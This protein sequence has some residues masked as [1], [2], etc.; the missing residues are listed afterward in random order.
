MCIYYVILFQYILC[1]LVKCVTAA[2]AVNNSVLLSLCM[3]LLINSAEY[4]CNSGY[5]TIQ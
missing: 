3:Q 4:A 5:D 2:A 1:M